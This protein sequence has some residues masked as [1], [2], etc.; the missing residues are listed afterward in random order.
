MAK[1]ESS[2][3]SHEDL[4]EEIGFHRQ[5]GGYMYS[6]VLG[7]I[8][9]IFGVVVAGFLI[10]Y[11]YPFP[12]SKGYRDLAGNIF[13][14]VGPII[15]FG[16]AYGL[17]RFIGQW[18]V[19]DQEK[20]LEYIRFFMWYQ[21]IS[22]T[23][24][25]TIFSIWTIFVIR[26]GNLAYLSWNLLFLAM[27]HYPGVLN[28]LKSVMAGLQHYHKASLLNTIGSEI[29][30]KLFLLIMIGWWRSYGTA[31][32]NLG[33]LM[34]MA[35]G[36]TFI[37]YMRDFFMF[38]LQI[39]VI[40]PILK[41][42]GIPLKSLFYPIFSKDTIITTLRSGLSVSFI[43]ILA[44]LNTY[45]IIMLYVGNIVNYTTFSVLSSTGLSF[46]AFIDYFGK[47][48]VAA[49]VSE[50]YLNA[51]FELARYYI[52]QVWK[53]WGYVTGSM[54]FAFLAFLNILAETI[55]AIPGL[56]NYALIG[57]FLLPAWI[58]KTFLPIAEQGDTILVSSMKLKSF[59]IIRLVEEGLR[60]VWI[61]IIFYIFR[62]QSYGIQAVAFCLIFSTAVP[63]WIK[64]IIVWIYINKKVISFKIPIWQAI[65]A[66]IGS[67]IGI[68][69]LITIFLHVGFPYLTS[70]FGP[71]IGGIIVIVLTLIIV[72]PIVFPFFY[73]LFGGWDEYGLQ[74]YEKSVQLAGPS[75]PFYFIAA[76]LTRLLSKI[77]PLTNKFKI[78]HESALI[79]MKELMEMKRKSINPI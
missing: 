50:A 7:F 62:W 11:L 66:P 2:S 58:Y 16:L 22:S 31:N 27:K 49:P 79:E 3:N 42:I 38:G 34:T 51:K 43:N 23:L 54:L 17:E 33:E 71:L 28:T 12:E 37:Y 18:R 1:K 52:A 73:G 6:Y 41:N 20:M 14:W 15:D 8:G 9:L 53:Y 48:D 77:S 40:R 32:P 36:T 39:Y 35:F 46:I 13:I 26:N 5:I 64:D 4:W 76:K 56:Q 72:P 47:I 68:Y 59:Q 19:K 61:L 44:T 57:T 78:P 21:L 29:M 30:D 70:W 25:T 67:G 74:I 55:L 75:K 10:S 45:L 69:F 24:K 65:I 60:I 63:Q